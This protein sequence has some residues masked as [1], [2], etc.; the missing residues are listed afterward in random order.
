MS[1]GQ[2]A[3]AV[4]HALVGWGLCGAAMGIGL[5]KTSVNRALVIHAIAAPLIFALVSAMY[6]T[7][8]AYTGALAT[9]AGFVAVVIAMD[10]FVVALLI[11][12]EF[13]MFRSVP[14]TWLPF[15]LIFASTY[16]VGRLIQS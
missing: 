2:I 5:A 11:Q 3:I 8:F 7:Y 9:A 13:S 1:L 15:A 12:R 16:A 14:G 4:A 10:V 6:F